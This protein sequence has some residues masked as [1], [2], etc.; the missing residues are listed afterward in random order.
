MMKKL[1][2]KSTIQAKMK[3]NKKSDF[4]LPVD[5]MVHVMLRQRSVN[6]PSTVDDMDHHRSVIG[7]S[8]AN[9]ARTVSGAHLEHI[10]STLGPLLGR[11][12]GG[13]QTVIGV[14]HGS[15]WSWP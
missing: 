3:L 12:R 2:K 5:D 11:V 13:Y 15:Q 7:F 6:G 1:K 14:R 10:W 4:P 8:L 9:A